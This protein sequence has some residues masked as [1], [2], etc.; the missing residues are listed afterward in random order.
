VLDCKIFHMT[1]KRSIPF[2]WHGQVFDG[3]Y[4]WTEGRHLQNQSLGNDAGLVEAAESYLVPAIAWRPEAQVTLRAYEPP[5]NFFLTLVET[6]DTLEALKLFADEYGLLGQDREL[7]AVK[8][9]QSARAV[10]ADRLTTWLDFLAELSAAVELLRRVQEARRLD[11]AGPLEDVVR[12]DGTDSVWYNYS[13]PERQPFTPIAHHEYHPEVLS[14]FAPGDLLG[15]AQYHFQDIVNA[16]LRGGL[17]GQLRRLPPEGGQ[18]SKLG[19][20][21]QPDSLAVFLWFQLA[22]AADAAKKIRRCVECGR[23]LVMAP[24]AD[25]EG[26]ISR[27]TCS[28][29]C[30]MKVYLKRKAE[31]VE[32]HTAGRTIEQIAQELHAEIASVRTWISDGA[33]DAPDELQQ[34]KLVIPAPPSRRIRLD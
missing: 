22:G 3:G 13:S 19:L 21:F 7:V 17:S 32:M 28:A 31:A 25:V 15:P 1:T 9:L 29:R 8:G 34:S 11:S 18:P 16:H 14:M 4:R 5:D 33:R 26:R 27:L 2:I 24:K 12:W 6:A 23:W 20:F 30:R 10:P